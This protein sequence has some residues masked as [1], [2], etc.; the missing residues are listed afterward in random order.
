M[1]IHKNQLEHVLRANAY[2][3]E[4]YYQTELQRL[5]IP[6]WQY[7]ATLDDLPTH[8]DFLTMQLF[9]KPLQVRNI[10]GEISV[11]LNVCSHRHC[12]LTDV[13]KGH[14][15]RFRCQYHGWEYT[16][17][18]RTRKIPD[19]GCFRP[20]DTENAR[21]QMYRTESCGRMIFVCLAPEGP[22]LEEFLGPLYHVLQA[23]FEP[24]FCQHWKWEADYNANWKVVTENSLESYHL[25]CVHPKTFAVI[26]PEETCEHELTERFTTFRTQE[27]FTWISTIQNWFVGK[28]GGE[29]SNIY[30]HHHIHPNLI[31]TGNDVHRLAI[32]NMPTSATTTRQIAWLF[33]LEG[34]RSD[35]LTKLLN[36]ML[37]RIVKY[38]ART[39]LLEDASILPAVQKGLTASP[40]RGAI[41]TREER[42]YVFQD[43]VRR[44]C[45][46]G[47]QGI[48]QQ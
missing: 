3:D 33:S 36:L 18:G 42:I 43:Y 6:S 12:M 2:F 39:A 21:L 40:F 16:K 35:P 26:P 25:A 38:V 10:E 47:L 4:S 44:S 32:L 7:V 9:G 13:K 30:T 27:T 22:S 48:V 15:P 45:G 5:F 14:D 41:G 31:C 11:F 24:P 23:S 46:D 1:F 19:A 34:Q 29:K 17:G 37:R 20:F 8:G 28:L